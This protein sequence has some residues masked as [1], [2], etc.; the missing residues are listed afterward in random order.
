MV[1]K[2][3]I[4]EVCFIC[5]K[6]H[7]ISIEIYQNHKFLAF[8]LKFHTP[9]YKIEVTTT[10]FLRKFMR[11]AFNTSRNSIFVKICFIFFGCMVWKKFIVE[12][13]IF[14]W[15]CRQISIEIPSKSQISC[16]LVE[17]SLRTLTLTAKISTTKYVILAM[18]IFL[19]NLGVPPSSDI[20]LIMRWIIGSF[21]IPTFDTY[22]RRICIEG[23]SR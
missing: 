2:K 13:C 3:F 1:W 23:H 8:L 17:I 7:Q 5:L 21:K 4:A 18:N 12:V 9:T 11:T 10:M 14:Y 6:Y 19:E 20:L 16:F 15:K 22:F